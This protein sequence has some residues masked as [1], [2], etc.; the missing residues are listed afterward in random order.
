MRHKELDV[1]NFLHNLSEATP[2]TAEER[3]Q[4]CDGRVGAGVE[5]LIL[6]SMDKKLIRYSKSLFY[7]TKINIY[8]T[9]L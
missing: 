6:Y 3:K 9:H 4:D 1:G 2:R 8:I 5:E 7:R